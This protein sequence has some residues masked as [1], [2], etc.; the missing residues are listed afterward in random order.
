MTQLYDIARLLRVYQWSKNALVLMPLVFAQQLLDSTAVLRS[1]IATAA[2][3]LA[4]SAAYIVNDIRDLEND[5]SHPINADARCRR[6]PSVH[7]WR[8]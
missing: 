1:L 7:Q 5:R 4:S 6:A 2:F 3:C 8:R